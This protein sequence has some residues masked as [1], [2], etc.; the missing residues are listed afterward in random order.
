MQFA[1][2]PPVLGSVVCKLRRSRGFL[3]ICRVLS[4]IISRCRRMT[5]RLSLLLFHR[6]FM[7][8]FNIF[9]FWTIGRY[10]T[11]SRKYSAKRG[12]LLSSPFDPSSS[13]LRIL[14]QNGE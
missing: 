6:R 12:L 13:G 1:D 7:L 2:A 14:E 10:S 11:A 9:T 5:W 3:V 4:A 8:A